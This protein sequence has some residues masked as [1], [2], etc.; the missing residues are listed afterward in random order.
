MKEVIL[1]GFLGDKYGT[2]WDIKASRIGDI[3]ACIECN[4]PEFRKDMIDFAES[5][6]D[7]SIMYGDKLLEDPEEFIYS[8]S[9]NTI[10][11]T[12]L[13]AG[14]KGGGAKLLLAGLIAAS[15]FIPGS[16][17][18]LISGGAIGGIGGGTVSAATALTGGAGMALGATASLNL[19]GLA[20]AGIATNLALTG[21]QQIMAPDPSVDEAAA[22][23][24]YLF[25][26]AQNT[27]AQNNVVPVL[28]G[29]MIV[30]GVLISTATVAGAVTNTTYAPTYALGSYSNGDRTGGST[31]ASTVVWPTS[32]ILTSYSFSR[33]GTR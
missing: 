30:G 32:E 9:E 28:F 31:S 33:I 14:A 4:Y 23:D 19:A 6:G 15:F 27:I 17:A 3:F 16:S 25:D 18:L 29:E 11:I 20:L 13:P 26:G 10:V 24:D 12:P 2:H 1:N 21:L 5:G 22:N 7:V 8:I